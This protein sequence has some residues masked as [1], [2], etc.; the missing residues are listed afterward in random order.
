MIGFWIVLTVICWV[1]GSEASW[2]VFEISSGI[3]L[4]F[5]LWP[6]L[7]GP[8]RLYKTGAAPLRMNYERLQGEFSQHL[9]ELRLRELNELGFELEGQIAHGAGVRNVANVLAFFKHRD[10]PDCAVLGT[11]ITGR[12]KI[13]LLIFRSRFSDGM[14]FTTSNLSKPRHV[15]PSPM[16]AG[17]RFPGV[18][19]AAALYRLHRKGMEE[20]G[21]SRQP[22]IDD[23]ESELRLYIEMS[24]KEHTRVTEEAGYKLGPK[25]DKYVPTVYAAIRNAWLLTWPVKQIR[26]MR[27]YSNGAKRARALGLPLKFGTL[28]DMVGSRRRPS[29]D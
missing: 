25:G 16:F 17:Y 1:I 7:N 11:I 15:K 22:V 29:P 5:F 6:F 9:P 23:G 28:E 21:S 14:T 13:P 4:A 26:I 2:Q 20:F 3:V 10:N 12:E 8:Y 27:L 24:E 19:P 18:G